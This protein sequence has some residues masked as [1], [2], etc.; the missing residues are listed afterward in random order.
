MEGSS[1][2][3]KNSHYFLGSCQAWK[4]LIYYNQ[5]ILGSSQPACGGKKCQLERTTLTILDKISIM[6]LENCKRSSPV[7]M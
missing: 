4:R 6:Y 7:Y 3:L 5:L 1:N 2:C